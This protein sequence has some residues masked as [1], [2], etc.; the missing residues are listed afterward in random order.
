[1]LQPYLQPDELPDTQLQV[2]YEY[3][4]SFVKRNDGDLMETLFS[5]NLAL[6]REF[7]Y[8]KGST[9]LETTRHLALGT[10]VQ[11]ITSLNAPPTTPDQPETASTT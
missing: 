1:M 3:A 10:I 6:F 2:L 7:D 5:I 11:T 4:M 9:D 8:V